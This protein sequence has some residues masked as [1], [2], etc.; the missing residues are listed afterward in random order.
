MHA[1][2]GRGN[3]KTRGSDGGVGRRERENYEEKVS[4]VRW[5]LRICL[6]GER[7]GRKHGDIR[8][9]RKEEENAEMLEG[10]ATR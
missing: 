10:K 5:V 9:E 3:R 8:R 2:G 7:R 6:D 1:E 4:A